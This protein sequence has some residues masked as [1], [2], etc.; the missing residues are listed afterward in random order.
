VARL[1]ASG[2]GKTPAKV[3]RRRRSLA[4][5]RQVPSVKRV[6]RWAS[7]G[8]GVASRRD[9]LHDA[10]AALQNAA[11]ACVSHQRADAVDAAGA[12]SRGRSALTAV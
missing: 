9:L 7:S 6:G 4:G 8:V 1:H 12:T 3:R 10:A 11:L 2:Y 5:W